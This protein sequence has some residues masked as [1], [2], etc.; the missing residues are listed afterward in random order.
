MI[1]TPLV[2]DS[3]HVQFLATGLSLPHIGLQTFNLLLSGSFL[4]TQENCAKVFILTKFVL[5]CCSDGY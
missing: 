4:E 3:L 1:H 2:Q 5:Q